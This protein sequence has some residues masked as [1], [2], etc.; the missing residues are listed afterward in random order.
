M[1][2]TNRG[3]VS[4]WG[5]HLAPRFVLQD[6]TIGLGETYRPTEVERLEGLIVV[7]AGVVEVIGAHGARGRLGAGALL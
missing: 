3:P 5:R 7:E 2:A 6:I 4:F 1:V